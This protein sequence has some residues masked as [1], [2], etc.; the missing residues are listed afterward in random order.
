M[1]WNNRNNI[2]HTTFSKIHCLKGEDDGNNDI[3]KIIYIIIYIIYRILLTIKLM[4]NEKCKMLY[5]VCCML[6]DANGRYNLPRGD[7]GQ[8]CYTRRR[9]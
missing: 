9:R 5:V 7:R 4:N 8:E 2:Q 1:C 6:F 3:I